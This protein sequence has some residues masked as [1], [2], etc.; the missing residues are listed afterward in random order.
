MAEPH[1]RN[2]DLR[3]LATIALSMGRKGLMVGQEVIFRA[4][5]DAYPDDALGPLGIA[6]CWFNEGR[7]AEAIAL[8]ER[9]A[10]TAATRADQARD[11]LDELRGFLVGAQ[12][13]H[14]GPA[15]TRVDAP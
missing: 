13:P 9:D 14:Q 11:A 1:D 6:L 3:L 12:A 2:D 7:H 15:A 8:I 4:W 5:R 10:V